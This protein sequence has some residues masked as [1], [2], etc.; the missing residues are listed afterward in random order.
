MIHNRVLFVL[1]LAALVAALMLSFL[2]FAPN[3]L[4]S[5]RAIPISEAMGPA[6]LGFIILCG[7]ALAFAAFLPQSRA[8]HLAVLAAALALS[9]ILPLT[10]G[11]AATRL[12]ATATP[13]ARASLASGFW[14]MEL[15]SVLAAGDALRRLD[16]GLAGKAAAV[17]AVVAVLVI[18]GVYGAFDQLSLAKEAANRREAFADAVQRHGFLVALSVLLALV[19]G[20]PLGVLAQ[21]R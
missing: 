21:R 10:A 4:V 19:I 14:I 5:G 3:R 16:A 17:I 6:S 2:G 7:A 8:L 1:V 9:V 15:S 12:V 11:A 20:L 18:A 13:I